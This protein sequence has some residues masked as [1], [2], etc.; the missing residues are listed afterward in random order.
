MKNN[1]IPTW[2]K[3]SKLTSFIIAAEQNSRTASNQFKNDFD[4]L[5]SVDEVLNKA[6]INLDNTI[7]WF[8]GFFLIRSHAAWRG[9]VRLATSG[10]L[11]ESYV[12]FRACLENA[13]YGFY[14]YKN[15]TSSKTWLSR[16]DSDEAKKKT[17]NEFT[18]ANVLNELKNYDDKLSGITS[19]LYERTIDYGGHPNP[20][21]L[22]TNSKQEVGD[23]K[24]V[25]DIMYMN[26]NP[27]AMKLALKTSAQVGVAVLKIFQKVFPHRFDI[28]NITTLIKQVEQGL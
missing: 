1:Q 6:A 5:V 18:Y 23:D 24:V 22:L 10:E 26:A 17:R 2:T 12:V 4:K 13:L 15:P 19:E 11:P 25:F 28:L 21:A 3:P 16:H 7:D 8:V 20:N 14:L 27:D 9:A